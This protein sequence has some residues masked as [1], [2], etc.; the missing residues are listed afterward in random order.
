MS[1]ELTV[2]ENT[3]DKK[4]GMA[5]SRQRADD[6]LKWAAERSYV[7]QILTKEGEDGYLLKSAIAKPESL[8]TA[9]LDIAN[10]GLSFS[11]ALGHAYLI[12]RKDKKTDRVATVR[13]VPSYKGLE[14]LVLATGAVI[15]IQSMVVYEKDDFD[16]LT[17]EDGVSIKHAMFRGKRSDRGAVEYS[18]TIARYPNGGRHVE[19]MDRHD[20]DQ[21]EKFA[22]ENA[23]G[24]KPKT[25][26]NWY[27]E[28]AKKC[29][30]RRAWK[31]W[32]KNVK[33]NK[34]IETMDKIEPMDFGKPTEIVPEAQEL[35]MTKRHVAQLRAALTLVADDRRDY[36]LDMMAKAMGHEKIQDVADNRYKEARTRLV[37]RMNKLATNK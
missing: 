18:Y 29:A 19:I 35:C 15:S 5:F 11:P 32:P 27:E 4:L 7:M 17:T 14:T 37:E 9:V 12:P 2:I 16:V 20:L 24:T 28:W 21:C 6:D 25:I 36:W 30:V 22:T 33:L 31:H 23:G 34:L 3:L 8:R 10:M 13:G 26:T 1:T